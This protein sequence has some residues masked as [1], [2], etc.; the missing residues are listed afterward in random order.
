M[1]TTIEINN[2]ALSQVLEFQKAFNMPILAPEQIP[3]PERVALRLKLMREEAKELR[4]ELVKKESI[5]DAAK[6]LADL[7]YVFWGTVAEFGYCREVKASTFLYPSATPT[8]PPI[9]I[10]RLFYQ[11]INREFDSLERVMNYKRDF[12]GEEI[13]ILYQIRKYID[14]ICEKMQMQSL[15]ETAFDE[16]HRSNMSKVQSDGTVKYREDGKVLK[17]DTYSKANIKGVLGL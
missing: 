17:P 1:K 7:Y 6:E 16:V 12:R 2:R 10:S 13:K 9:S 3:T 11:F 5:A 8:F 14:S 15:I 4:D